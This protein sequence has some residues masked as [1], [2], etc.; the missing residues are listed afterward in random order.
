M[1]LYDLD[2]EFEKMIKQFPNARRKLVEDSGSKMYDKVMANISA[3]VKDKSGNLKNG[4]TKAVG[5]GGG[6]AAVRPNRKVAPHTHLIENG[7]KVVRNGK[8]VG[9]VEGKHMY[10]NAL[11]ELANELERDA[12]KMLDDLVGDFNG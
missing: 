10:R 1:D 12:E 6:Y 8:V 3:N 5:S 7:H 4:V 9:W 2:K 11:N